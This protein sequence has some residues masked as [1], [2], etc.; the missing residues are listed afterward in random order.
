MSVLL[1]TIALLGLRSTNAE[2]RTAVSTTPM[3]HTSGGFGD[4]WR[5]C[6][7]LHTQLFMNFVLMRSA[8]AQIASELPD[9]QHLRGAW[10]IIRA[11]WYVFDSWTCREFATC[12]RFELGSGVCRK[13]LGR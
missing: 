2:A 11:L 9:L 8:L 10:C 6:R 3:P 1:D 12:Q 13:Q 5:R 7:Q 4:I